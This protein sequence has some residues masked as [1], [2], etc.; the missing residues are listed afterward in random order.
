[1]LQMKAAAAPKTKKAL[2]AQN[3]R[4]RKESEGEREDGG[5]ELKRKK[6]RFTV[7]IV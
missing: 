7:S 3:G 5:E 1:M 2:I 6:V 4:K